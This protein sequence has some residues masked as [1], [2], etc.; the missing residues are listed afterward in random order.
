MLK[1]FALK[2]FAPLMV[3]LLLPTALLAQK[4]GDAP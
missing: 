1:H 3:L 2:H 4:E